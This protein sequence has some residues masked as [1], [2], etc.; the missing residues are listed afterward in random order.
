V[1]GVSGLWWGWCDA[2]DLARRAPDLA[3]KAVERCQGCPFSLLFLGA[4]HRRS[5][6]PG[7]RDGEAAQA[8]GFLNIDDAFCAAHDGQQLA[9]WNAHHDERGFASMHIYRGK[10]HA[11]GDDLR[12][13]RTPKGI[14]DVVIGRTPMSITLVIAERDTIRC[15]PAAQDL[16]QAWADGRI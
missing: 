8:G 1:N 11:G 10:R 12:P 16:L 5:G 15:L 13:A 2:G 14:E 4:A 9:F 7:R 3:R 6:R